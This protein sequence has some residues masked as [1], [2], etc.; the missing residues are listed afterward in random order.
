MMPWVFTIYGAPRTKKTHNVLATAGR[1]GGRGRRI[2][3]PSKAWERWVKD[4]R[5]D[6]QYGA[7]G[8][9]APIAV[10]VPV[11][12]SAL[13]F[14][15]AARGDAV[16]YYQGLADLLEKRGVV[17]NDKLIVTW[18]GSRLLKDTTTPRVIVV[19]TAAAEPPFGPG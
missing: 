9:F 3:L 8:A 5:F 12:C 6:W 2:V 15:D 10:S 11:N 18:D 19:L 4:A 7:V 14:C 1:P 17:T 16:G 13:F